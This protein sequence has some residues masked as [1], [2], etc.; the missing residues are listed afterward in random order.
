MPYTILLPAGY[1]AD[2]EQRY[3]VLYLLHGRYS[4]H[5]AWVH[6]TRLPEHARRFPM[7]IVCPE[8]ELGNDMNGANGERWE[9]DLVTDLPAHI[10]ATYRTRTDR[11]GRAIAGLSMG[12]FGAF[13]CGM[14]HPERYCA[15]SCHAG[16]F[17]IPIWDDRTWPEAQRAVLG[18]HGGPTRH[19][20]D[21]HRIIEQAMRA[22][23]PDALPM[24]A[25]DCGTED[26]PHLLESNRALHRTLTRLGVHHFYREGPGGHEWA[27]FDREV[28]F[29]LQFV[30][31]AMGIIPSPE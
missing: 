10:E 23:G 29:T 30:A 19:E 8:G 25:I 16:G 26:A 9:D 22:D 28:P 5:H 4:D 21:P 7:I 18:P 13:S 24:L 17:G 3:P 27:Y 15:I 1:D 6:N 12:G 2:G 20:Y 11:S 14:R 31:A